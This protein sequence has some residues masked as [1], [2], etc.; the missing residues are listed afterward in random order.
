MFL[1]SLTGGVAELLASLLFKHYESSHPLTMAQL[2]EDFDLVTLR[3]RIR[4]RRHGHFFMKFT[5]RLLNL[6]L[7]LGRAA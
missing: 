1:L 2:K 3:T 6:S 5:L 7:L 4:T